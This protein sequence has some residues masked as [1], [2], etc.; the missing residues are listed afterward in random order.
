MQG[1]KDV[2]MHL[3]YS[4]TN[5]CLALTS[6]LFQRFISLLSVLQQ[7]GNI[8]ITA[9]LLYF[10][11][12]RSILLI[13]SIISHLNGIF[14]IL[15][16]FTQQGQMF[17]INFHC[18]VVAVSPPVHILCLQQFINFIPSQTERDATSDNTPCWC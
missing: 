12:L 6:S 10:D 9:M 13:S 17:R 18:S 15:S 1:A 4:N 2:I 11:A 16:S 8:S 3:C 5:V 7:N 14:I